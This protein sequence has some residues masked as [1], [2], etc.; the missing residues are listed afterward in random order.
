[1]ACGLRSLRWAHAFL[2][3]YVL[4][5]AILLFA[6]PAHAAPSFSVADVQCGEAAGSCVVTIRKSA[7]A[8]S[9]SKV[10]VS[11]AD[12]TA[13]AGTD[14]RPPVATTLTFANSQL[15][16]T[17]SIPILNDAIAEGPETFQVRLTAVRFA[18]IARSPATVTIVDDDAAPPGVTWTK[19]ADEDGICSV[20][21]TANVRYGHGSV[22]T[23]PRGVTGSILCN[24]GTWGDPL[25]GIP[26]QCDTDGTPGTA[27][28]RPPDP[29]PAP[30]PT[31]APVPPANWVAAPLAVG[32]YGLSKGWVF[33]LEA[34]T[35]SADADP[36]RRIDIYEGTFVADTTGQV[37]AIGGD[38]WR[39][40]HYRLQAPDLTGV[41]PA[42]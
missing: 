15:S 16:A 1:M 4:L 37:P 39:G 42:P 29:T 5:I 8:N 25:V 21:G 18:S 14:Y 12:G 3:G 38:Y 7:K 26:K 11:T 22:W 2:V 30:T 19:C 13:I 34:V 10:A 24:N 32:G 17:V 35:R 33:K 40:L 27:P 36:A 41:A 9:Y 23:A 20:V 6:T 31:P 28:A